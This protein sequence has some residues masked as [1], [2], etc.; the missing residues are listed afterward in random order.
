MSLGEIVGGE[1][2]GH[3]AP[4]ECEPR[5]DHRH[6]G[7]G[8]APEHAQQVGQQADRC[9]PGE[10]DCDRQFLGRVAIAARR[11]RESRADH[12]D[13]DRAHRHVLVASRVLAEHPLGEEHQH[14]QTGG[15]RRL[16]E[17][18]RSQQQGQHL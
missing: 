10:H 4:G 2:G 6:R 15:E 11:G 18:Q 16:H 3:A 1:L 13:H 14:Q 17:D 5:A 7:R 9:E 12:A 8:S